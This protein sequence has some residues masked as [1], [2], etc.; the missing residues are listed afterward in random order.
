MQDTKQQEPQQKHRLGTISKLTADKERI[1]FVCR[2]ASFFLNDS[3]VIILLK[4]TMR[5][6]H[7][8]WLWRKILQHLTAALAVEHFNA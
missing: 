8:H 3:A 5:I 6:T 2:Y 4:D 1:L 7:E